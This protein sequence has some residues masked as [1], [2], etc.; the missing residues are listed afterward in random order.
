[1]TIVNIH[2]AK[3]NL[4]KLISQIEEGSENEIIIA[5]NGRPAARLVPLPPKKQGLRLGIAA[6]HHP[7]MS[8]EGFQA[9]DAD[10][11]RLF[12]GDAEQ[13]GS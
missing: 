10:V 8:F 3:S 1:M 13:R 11:G 9:L 2:E 4:S 7:P 12:D 5:R 6:G